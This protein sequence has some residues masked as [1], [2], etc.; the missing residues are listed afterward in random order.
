VRFLLVWTIVR[1]EMPDLK[2]QLLALH[3]APMTG[4]E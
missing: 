4:D 3:D 1:T 2:A